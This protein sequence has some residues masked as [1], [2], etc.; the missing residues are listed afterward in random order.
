MHD[1]CAVTA[2]RGLAE[3]SGSGSMAP[4]ALVQTCVIHELTKPRCASAGWVES[5][6]KT[7]PTRYQRRIGL[8][9][10]HRDVETKQP[11]GLSWTPTISGD[12]ATGCE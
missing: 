2:S 11:V 1:P 6:S 9:E 7:M 5:H 8:V 12:T 3:R 4:F 10:V